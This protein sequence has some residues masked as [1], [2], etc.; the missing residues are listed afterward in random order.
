MLKWVLLLMLLF[1]TSCE[2][3]RV[4]ERVGVSSEREQLHFHQLYYFMCLD[5]NDHN[6]EACSDEEE[7]MFIYLK[8]Y[9]AMK[10]TY[11]EKW[12]VEP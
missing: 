12:N 4:A 2:S 11:T 8:R 10:E 6:L 9:Q 1:L 3:T 7:M 5:K